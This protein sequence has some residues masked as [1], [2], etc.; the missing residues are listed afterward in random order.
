VQKSRLSQL[1][2]GV[3]AN[4]RGQRARAWGACAP[5][6][7]QDNG[8]TC[9]GAAPSPR[10]QSGSALTAPAVA[11]RQETNGDHQAPR[12]A[13]A[14][15]TI[16]PLTGQCQTPAAGATSCALHSRPPGAG[17]GRR[18][19]RQP[20]GGCRAAALLSAANHVYHAREPALR[21]TH[22]HT[23]GRSH[24]AVVVRGDPPRT[25]TPLA[26]VRDVPRDRGVAKVS[27]AP[28]PV[29]PPG[30]GCPRQAPPATTSA[31][32]AQWAELEP[33]RCARTAEVGLL[34]CITPSSRKG[35]AAGRAAVR[36]RAPPRPT[37]RHRE[38][39]PAACER[40]LLQGR[41]R[42]CMAARAWRWCCGDLGVHPTA[43]CRWV[44][45]TSPRR[46]AC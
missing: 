13:K 7:R 19:A 15:A 34:S 24:Q 35:G 17:G 43:G 44:A 36:P 21:H 11:V 12:H 25:T 42:A 32:A 1:A 8:A 29:L 5:H 46:G 33:P 18:V 22:L 26:S 30:R 38:L 6:G 37:P 41:A 10:A 2:R 3:G 28:A 45:G 39:C 20:G 9:A 23:H 27:A 40:A 31:L 14:G 16:M 4:E